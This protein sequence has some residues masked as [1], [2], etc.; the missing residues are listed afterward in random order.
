MPSY[1]VTPLG[2][3]LGCP[4]LTGAVG[5][6]GAAKKIGL[7]YV[8]LSGVPDSFI[9][10][11]EEPA[12]CEANG[13]F[14]AV[15]AAGTFHG[16]AGEK[17]RQ[18]GAAAAVAAP[19]GR[20]MSAMSV[21]RHAVVRTGRTRVS[22]EGRDIQSGQVALGGQSASDRPERIPILADDFRAE[23]RNLRGSTARFFAEI[24]ES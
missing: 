10:K 5:L 1:L 24:L 7:E 15:G 17:A 8:G 16:L 13:L 6:P 19:N 21:A 9:V 11:F 3:Q 4:T 14:G 23:S 20:T 12:N 22:V 2:D 18:T